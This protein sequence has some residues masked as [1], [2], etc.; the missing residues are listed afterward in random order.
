MT[1]WMKCR[2]QRSTTSRGEPTKS[3]SAPQPTSSPI[4]LSGAKYSNTRPVVED[5]FGGRRRQQKTCLSHHIFEGVSNQ[6][7]YGTWYILALFPAP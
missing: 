6:D 2:G 7:G 5:A 3:T 4:P 1:A